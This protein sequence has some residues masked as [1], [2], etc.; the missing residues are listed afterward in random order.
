MGGSSLA[1]AVFASL[2]R[3]IPDYLPLDVIDT[4]SPDEISRIAGTDLHRCLF[5]VSSKSGTTIETVDLYHHFHALLAA[6]VASAES[7]FVLITDDGSWLHQL[8]ESGNFNHVFINPAD[9]GG[10]YS[11]LSYFGLV[12]AAL[13]GVDVGR[14]LKKTRD[15]CETTKSDD[16]AHNPALALGMLLGRGALAG[17]D[18]LMLHLPDELQ[19]L[20]LWIEQL[21]AESTG[22]NGKGLVPVLAG[23]GKD[24]SSQDCIGD[25]EDRINISIGFGAGAGPGTAKQ[26]PDR[27]QDEPLNKFMDHSLQLDQPGQ[28]GA[29]F[30]RWEFATAIAA[31]YLHINPFDEPNVAQAKHSTGLFIEGRKQLEIAPSCQDDD[32][33]L[34]CSGIVG[35]PRS[36][37]STA[38]V[39]A[40]FCRTLVPK[41]YVGILAYLPE[42]DETM[43]LLHSLGDRLAASFPIVTTLGMGPRYLH[44]TGQLHK[45][46]PPSG[47]FIQF[48]SD[49]KTDLPVPGRSYTFGQLYRA[50]ADGDFSVLSGNGS[51]IMRVA[52]KADR[53]LALQAFIAYFGASLGVGPK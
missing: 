37:H 33:T 4:T 8:A 17:K 28:I 18:K 20:G 41:T 48:V 11:V 46:G 38:D 52:L 21:V 26:P 24:F 39:L 15:F 30:F 5:I 9:I 1:P 40:G 22:K 34:T 44:S 16:P 45:G 49:S 10:R 19:P 42:D 51:T 36:A 31:S 14:L 7:R 53:P 47:R 35:V 13:L 6:Q 2:F 12:P 50:Q 32:Y 43:A 3:S 23:D 29:E 25:E 27:T